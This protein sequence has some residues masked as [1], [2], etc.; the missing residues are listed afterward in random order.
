[1][2]LPCC[3][4][5]ARRVP[6]SLSAPCCVKPCCSQACCVGLHRMMIPLLCAKLCPS[7]FGSGRCCQHCCDCARSACVPLCLRRMPHPNR[8][9]AIVPVRLVV[10]PFWHDRMKRVPSLLSAPHTSAYAARGPLPAARCPLPAARVGL[11]M[12]C[13]AGRKLPTTSDAASDM[14]GTATSAQSADIVVAQVLSVTPSNT[15]SP[16]LLSVPFAHPFV[17][18]YMSMLG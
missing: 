14:F 4:P 12:L 15:H 9:E 2:T 8:H 16:K 5:S 3:W 1:L 13:C 6:Y 11:C 18:S 17:C 10:V 7:G